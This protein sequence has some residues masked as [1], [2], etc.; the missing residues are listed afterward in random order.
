M[1][2]EQ[3]DEIDPLE[4]RDITLANIK[5]PNPFEQST[6]QQSIA[7]TNSS[8]AGS[9][10]S[11]GNTT[12]GEEAISGKHVDDKPKQHR[13]GAVLENKAIGSEEVSIQ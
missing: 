4:T 7:L 5:S 11:A 6:S 10:S 1:R 9:S 2:N 12:L 13:L 3:I 8:R